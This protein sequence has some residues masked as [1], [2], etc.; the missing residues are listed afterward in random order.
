MTLALIITSS[1]RIRSH[2]NYLLRC[3]VLMFAC[4]PQAFNDPDTIRPMLTGY[5]LQKFGK[6]VRTVCCVLNP[7]TGNTNTLVGGGDGTVSFVNQSL[8]KVSL[9]GRRLHEI[10]EQARGNRVGESRLRYAGSCWLLQGD[11]LE[12]HSTAPHQSLWRVQ[13]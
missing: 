11:D 6:G 12:L 2:N 7:A 10:G 8:V 9:N 3:V 4:D 5:S 13:C 1:F